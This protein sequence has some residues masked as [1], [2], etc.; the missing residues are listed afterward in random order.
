MGRGTNAAK[1]VA[2]DT[3]AKGAGLFPYA[4]VTLRNEIISCAHTATGTLFL[5]DGGGRSTWI[6]AFPGGEDGDSACEDAQLDV[7]HVRI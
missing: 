2:F 5:P 7:I 1:T 6:L 4:Q 3:S